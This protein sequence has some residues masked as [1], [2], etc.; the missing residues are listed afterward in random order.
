MLT[1]IFLPNVGMGGS[2][3]TA[4]AEVVV[5]RGRDAGS[6]RYDE[7]FRYW[8]I[9]ELYPSE[10]ADKPL[11]E[12]A[13]EADAF[14]PKVNK[15]GLDTLQAALAET[16]QELAALS[17]QI[18][19][20]RAQTGKTLKA[21]ERTEHAQVVRE[22]RGVRNAL[23]QLRKD[24]KKYGDLLEAQDKYVAFLEE[25]KRRFDRMIAEDA[26]ALDLITKLLQ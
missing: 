25:K 2:D 13:R 11:A 1:L 21:L 18:T 5:D 9:D 24:A 20:I 22:Q 10:I 17:A 19:E 16:D 26:L 6:G 7:E 23:S 15:A 3:S 4:V 14:V 12:Q 8:A